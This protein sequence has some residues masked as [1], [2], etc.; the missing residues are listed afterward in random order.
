MDTDNDICNLLQSDL[1]SSP[2]SSVLDIQYKREWDEYFNYDFDIRSI[3]NGIFLPSSFQ[4]PSPNIDLKMSNAVTFSF[5]KKETLQSEN[6]DND[7]LVTVENV[8][9]NTEEEDDPFEN[10]N[11]FKDRIKPF[12]DYKEIATRFVNDLYKNANI[13]K[14]EPCDQLSNLIDPNVIDKRNEEINSLKGNSNIDFGSQIRNYVLEPYSLV[15]DL[16]SGYESNM[17]LKVLDGELMPFIDAY[18]RMR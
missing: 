10:E 2:P 3:N 8:N 13:D 15:K 4:E 6:F 17:P 7:Y 9:F 1:P 12:V 14:I 11:L 5:R 16:R 18:I